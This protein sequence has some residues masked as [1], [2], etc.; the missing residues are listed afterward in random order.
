MLCAVLVY[1]DA[2]ATGRRQPSRKRKHSGATAASRAWW[3]C[4]S[5][6]SRMQARLILGQAV[7][8]PQDEIRLHTLQAQRVQDKVQQ[9]HTAAAASDRQGHIASAAG[10]HRRDHKAVHDLTEENT[11]VLQQVRARHRHVQP[12]CC[13]C[14]CAYVIFVHYHCPLHGLCTQLHATGFHGCRWAM[15]GT[16]SAMPQR[17]TLP[18]HQLSGQAHDMAC[19]HPCSTR[20]QVAASRLQAC[21]SA[22]WQTLHRATIPPALW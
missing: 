1:G 2:G 20:I 8:K 21:H 14:R 13:C 3:Q 15:A 17:M 5:E 11:P 22:G 4:D 10:D 7:Q 19:H 12:R 6:T 16:S 18:A 9:A